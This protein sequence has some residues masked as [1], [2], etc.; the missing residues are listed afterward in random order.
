MATRK[1]EQNQETIAKAAFRLFRDNGF[2]KTSIKNIADAAGI[3]KALV[4][5]YFPKKDD[6]E[7][8]I[9][10][11]SL[12]IA[13][14]FV[15][16]LI[17]GDIDLLTEIYLMGYFE[18]CYITQHESMLKLGKD[19]M[20]SRDLTRSIR[21]TLIDWISETYHLDEEQK[22]LLADGITYSIGAAF[23][24]VYNDLVEGTPVD[25]DEVFRVAAGILNAITGRKVAP[26]D[27]QALMPRDW[28]KKKFREMDRKMFGL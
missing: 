7:D 15:E 10:T 3:Q 27:V 26:P 17:P 21:N 2:E 24:Y 11:R 5:Y 20:N 4:Q 23:E 25:V 18:L 16:D 6:F 28:M 14:G 19:I 12:D 13:Q 9:L 1:F 8:L 22:K